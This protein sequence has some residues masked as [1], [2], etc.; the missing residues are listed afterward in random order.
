M[1]FNATYA[2]FCKSLKIYLYIQYLYIEKDHYTSICREG[3]SWIKIDDA[4]ALLQK[5]NGLKVL[6][7]FIYYFYK[8]LL[9]N[10]CIK[11][12]KLNINTCSFHI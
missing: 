7:I 6:K 9:L 8:K 11:Q 5:R 12:H 10:T 1:Q 2:I 4:Q 3:T